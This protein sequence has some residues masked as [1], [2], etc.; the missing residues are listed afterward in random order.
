M[1]KE[2]IVIDLNFINILWKIADRSF[3]TNRDNIIV[4]AVISD[5]LIPTLA[6]SSALG[7]W[8]TFI[9]PAEAA[10]AEKDVLIAKI[11]A[12][13]HIKNDFFINMFLLFA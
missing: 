1:F 5:E 8:P 11:T 13:V 2:T 3:L 10:A 6:R 7:Y 4:C 12:A 9:V